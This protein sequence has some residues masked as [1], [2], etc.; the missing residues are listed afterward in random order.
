MLSL[1]LGTPLISWSCLGYWSHGPIFQTCSKWFI[2]LFWRAVGEGSE[3]LPKPCPPLVGPLWG[4]PHLPTL[5][6]SEA[7][8]LGSWD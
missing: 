5:E 1:R 8:A 2:F 6:L 4:L 7:L 3:V